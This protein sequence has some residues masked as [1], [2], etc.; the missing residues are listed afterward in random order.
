LGE[1]F[2]LEPLPP[3]ALF[4]RGDEA[5]LVAASQVREGRVLYATRGCSRC[6]ALPAGVKLGPGAMPEMHHEAPSLAGAGAR[7]RPAWLARWLA[8]PRSLRPEATMPHVLHGREAAQNAADIAAYLATSIAPSLTTSQGADAAAGQKHFQKLG[9]VTC[10]HLQE[11]TRD[12]E[13]KR[14]SL[15]YVKAK[16]QDGALEAFLR[17]PHQHYAWIRM[18]DFKLSAKEAADL[19]A[20]LLREAAGA[21]E[22]PPSPGSAARGQELFRTVGC[23]QC[24]RLD[25]ALVG[26]FLPAPR[27]MTQGCLAEKHAKAPDFGFNE[28]QRKALTAFLRSDGTSLL[29][30][31]PAEFSRRQTQALQCQAC[32]RRDGASS[33]WHQVLEDEG[34]MPEAL[35]SLTWAGQK[36]KHEWAA[37]LLA[38]QADQRARPWLK[39]RMPAFPACAEILAQGLSHEHGYSIHEPP[40][41]PVNR[42][43]AALGAKLL[44]QQGGFN[45]IMCHG[46]GTRPALEPF[47]APGINLLD[48]AL[49]LRH[50][51]YLRW[52]LN[53]AR[54]DVVTRMP[55]FAQDGKTTALRDTLDGDAVRQFEAIWNYMRTLK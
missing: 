32:H 48:A 21:L 55:V 52:M 4:S 20:Y 16:F 18:P 25:T 3:E 33:R 41:P 6:H 36:L 46:V 7:F 29:R 35:P 2:G 8:A 54:V 50:E 9:C 44:P 1:G 51:Y 45:C 10:H 42:E 17:Q 22:G 19:A 23:A 53:P 24:H 27:A 14:L 5:D 31:T 43:L 12:D 47:E 39:A 37:R 38:G 13:L 28:E 30:E 40:L 15:Y 26:A 49:R 34:K 11:P